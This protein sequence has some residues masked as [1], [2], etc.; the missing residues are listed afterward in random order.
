MEKEVPKEEI[1]KEENLGG[2]TEKTGNTENPNPM[3]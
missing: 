2:N 3:T 1:K